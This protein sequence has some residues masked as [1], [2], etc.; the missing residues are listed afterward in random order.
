MRPKTTATAHCRLAAALLLLPL[1][2]QAGPCRG[3]GF[4]DSITALNVGTGRYDYFVQVR[5]HT[6]QSMAMDLQIANMP[7]DVSVVSPW[8]AGV[9]L[10]PHA[11]QTIRFGSGTNS[12]INST[13]VMVLYDV[14]QTSRMSA[15]LLN[16][17]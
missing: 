15:T 17:L 10:Q 13:T 12:R 16:C 4:I 2:A 6:N 9:T 8:F 3:K 1:V 14:V 11:T 7:V 5:N